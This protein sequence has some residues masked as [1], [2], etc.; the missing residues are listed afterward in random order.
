MSDTVDSSAPV[1]SDPAAAA[2]DPSVS[3]AAPAT[4]EAATDAAADSSAPAADASAA[5]TDQG[6]SPVLTAESSAAVV[7]DPNNAPVAS[8]SYTLEQRV[9]QLEGAV[10]HLAAQVGQVQI[11]VLFPSLGS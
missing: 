5:P 1:T 2:S 10:K 4:D 7:S 3:S 8:P 9:S 6:G 11:E